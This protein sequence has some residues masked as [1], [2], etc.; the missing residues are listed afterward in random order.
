MKRIFL[1]ALS[2]SALAFGVPALA[3]AHHAGH[4]ARCASAR[5]HHHARCARAHVLAFGPLAKATAG[6]TTT[7]PTTSTETAGKITAFVAPK[8]TIT[9]ND[10]TEISGKVTSDTEIEC[11]S[12][13]TT[14]GDDEGDDDGGTEGDG[15]DSAALA[16]S[17]GD[18]ARIASD[19]SSGD[20]EGDDDGGS[21]TSCTESALVVGA[22]VRAAELKIGDEGAV[23]EKL[24]LVS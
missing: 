3:S 7:A 9:L 1:T 19:S 17:H 14:G 4:H 12:T 24:I 15:G 21:T 23:W 6:A 16:S 8:L 10:G 18:S 2:I 13:T 22:V 5:H 11:E 20:D